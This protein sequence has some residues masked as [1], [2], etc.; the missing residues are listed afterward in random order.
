MFVLGCLDCQL[1][2][3]NICSGLVKVRVP[4][5]HWDYG[6]WQSEQQHLILSARYLLQCDQLP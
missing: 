2:S 6:G 4:L 1:V 5:H 3:G